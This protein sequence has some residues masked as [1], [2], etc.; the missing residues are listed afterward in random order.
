V[1][2]VGSGTMFISGVS[3]YTRYV[4]AALSEHTPTAAILMR[5]LIPRSLYPGRARV[6]EPLT[7]ARYPPSV[8]VLDG[9]DWFWGA[10]M[11]RALCLLHRRR[12]RAVVFEWW[13]GA[14]LH[15]YLLLALAARLLG[16][17]VIVELHEMQDT[18][19]AGFP[20]ARVYTRLAGGILM[21]LAHSFVVHS[22]FDRRALRESYPVT[23]RRCEVVLHGPYS[24]YAVTEAEPLR[25]APPGV[26]NILFFGTIRP[27]KGLEDLVRAFELL[28]AGADG[29]ADCWLTVVGETW[30][31][32]R[33][34]LA[35]IE[36]SPARARI[37]LVNEYVSDAEAARWFAGADVVALPYRR[38]SASGPLHVAMDAGLPVVVGD[39][40]G[41]GEACA[42]YDGA[43]T[44][45]PADPSALHAGLTR[46]IA[47]RGARYA[48]E[49]S[50]ERTA[51]VL[52]ALCGE[53]DERV[54]A[55]V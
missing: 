24:H 48:D 45:A 47:L 37:T 5:R 41:L 30:E 31:G 2:V 53:R 26:C 27:Y 32:W 11:L 44:V 33:E 9:V 40:G 35:L 54:P 17:R 29:A 1:V 8:Q 21:R 50:W 51:E 18:G 4:S 12:P 52:L 19:E 46:A 14:V 22:E 43:V 15:S 6:G 39:V 28:V 20:P 7:D 13:T 42:H 38:S 34:P 3:H 25:E 36:R 10:G 55:G 16:A 23:G 49:G